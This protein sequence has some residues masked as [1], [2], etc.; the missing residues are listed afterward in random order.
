MSLAHRISKYNRDRKW[1]T[2][3]KEFPPTPTMHVLDIGF[4]E[5]EYSSTDNYIEKH[6]PYQNMLTA[7]GIDNPI[8]FKERYPSVRAIRYDGGLFPFEDK[9]FDVVWSNA[10]IEHVGNRTKQLL[11][12]KEIH[13]VS[14]CAFITTPNKYFPVEVHTRTPLLH[15]LPKTIFDKYLHLVGKKWASGEYMHLL[16]LSDIES[17]FADAGIEEYRIYKNKIAGFTLDFVV[18]F[19]NQL[20][21]YSDPT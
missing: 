21:A 19:G 9:L 15:Y 16:S 12:L 14:N 8:R 3:I 18:C 1:R 6:Y 20:S 7:L 10:V 2:F 17:L 5:N 13:R 4:S 11:F